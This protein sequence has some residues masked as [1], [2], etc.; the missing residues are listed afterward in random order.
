MAIRQ[1]GDAIIRIKY[2][3]RGDYAGTITTPEGHRWRFEDL[4]APKVG[5]GAN[6]AYDS[7]KAYDKMAEA[8]V[9][10]GSYYTTMNRGDETPSWAPPAE[11]ADAIEEAAIGAMDPEGR[12]T[13]TVTRPKRK[14]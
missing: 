12:G 10:F 6:V 14:S 5:F 2:R 1:I 9:S 11:V 8:A 7:P 3:D 13:Y 4:H